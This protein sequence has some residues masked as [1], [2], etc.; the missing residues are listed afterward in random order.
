MRVLLHIGM[1]K[2]GSTALQDAFARAR[3]DLKALG[4]L[5][6]RGAFNHNFLVAGIDTPDR[7]G[8]VFRQH[9]AGNAEAVG[10][11]FAGFWRTIVVAIERHR[12]SVVL[13]SAESLFGGL[14]RAGPEP[15]RALLVPLSA[16]VEIVVYVRRPSDHY[17]SQVQ[18]Q[19]K[20]SWA[21]RPA[22][23]VVYRPPLAA[24]MAVADRLHVVPFDRSKFPGEDIV[25]DFA[26]RFLPEASRV[27]SGGTATSRNTSMSAEAMDILQA[28][29]RDHHPDDND[30]FTLDTGEFRRRLAEC[31]DRLGGARRPELLP[32][33][34]E[35]VDQTS[36]D[37]IWLRDTF[38]IVFDGIDYRAV[39]AGSPIAVA[40]VGDICLIDPA[41][42]AELADAMAL[43]S[44]REVARARR[45]RTVVGKPTRS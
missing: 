41:R 23:P 1:S 24:A 5:Y 31:E 8:R 14:G 13:M 36:L 20:A 42:R 7:F 27:L 45:F 30:R 17:L 37:L 28:Y 35:R 9:Y 16:E 2:A 10:S 33:V 6:P 19:L 29:R 26:S 11:D 25:A 21:I 38:G 12:P 4:I 18:Q 39:A 40:T 44:P 43:S 3:R 15:L 34:R 32:H 22:G